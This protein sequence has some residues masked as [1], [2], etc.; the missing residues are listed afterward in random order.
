VSIVRAALAYVGTVFG[1][2]FVLGTARIFW[3]APRI[4]ARAAELMEM[5]VMVLTTLLAARWVSRRAGLT[6]SWACIATGALALALLVAGEVVVGVAVRRVSVI[7]AFTNRDSVSG[8][9]YYFSLGVFAI[10]P[11]LMARPRAGDA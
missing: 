11:W 4:G 7:D 9:A 2:G 6:R 1:V 10:A 3:V 5:P 8:V